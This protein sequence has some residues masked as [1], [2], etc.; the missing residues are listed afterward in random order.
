MGFVQQYHGIRRKQGIQHGLPQQH[1]IGSID[2]PCIHGRLVVESDSIATLC[3]Q[4]TILLLGN[5]FCHRNRCY[6]TWLSDA[7][8]KNPALGEI[9]QFQN[10]LGNL[11]RFSTPCLRHDQDDIIVD[12]LFANLMAKL[13][14]K[15]CRKG[16][17]WEREWSGNSLKIAKMQLTL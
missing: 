14:R 3:S 8:G 12:N 13:K 5:P 4:S 9:C 16:K 17:S 1:P 7:N 11:S 2:E 6:S 15:Y 10:V